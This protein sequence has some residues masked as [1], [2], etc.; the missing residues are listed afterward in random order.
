MDDDKNINNFTTVDPLKV[1]PRSQTVRNKNPDLD[2]IRKISESMGFSNN[3]QTKKKK[4]GDHWKSYLPNKNVKVN[5]TNTN[6]N[7]LTAAHSSIKQIQNN[8]NDNSFESQ[9][10]EKL[11]SSLIQKKSYNSMKKLR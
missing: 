2:T 1:V 7:Y 8:K 5:A 10:Q 6:A 11:N 4:T 9:V 3:L